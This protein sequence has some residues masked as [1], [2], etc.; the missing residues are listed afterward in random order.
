MEYQG[1]LGQIFDP[2]LLQKIGKGTGLGL[3]ISLGIIKE[4]S[5]SITVE[6]ELSK[7]SNSQ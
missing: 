6:S 3:A 2:F 7:G 4:H 1:K 5:G